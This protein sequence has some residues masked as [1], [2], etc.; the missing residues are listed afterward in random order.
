[1]GDLNIWNKAENTLREVLDERSKGKWHVNEEDAAFY[2]PKVSYN[3]EFF[4]LAVKQ[5]NF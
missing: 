2:G 4:F 3:H 5:R 1:M